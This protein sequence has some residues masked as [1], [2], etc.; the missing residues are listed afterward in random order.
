MSLFAIVFPLRFS[1]SLSLTYF[2]A[3]SSKRTVV[4]YNTG[5]FSHGCGKTFDAK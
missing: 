2:S 3:F 5:F 4:E 1:L